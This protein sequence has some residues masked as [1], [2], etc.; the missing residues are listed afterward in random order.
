M[1]N[2]EALILLY[3]A[4]GGTDPLPADATNLDVLNAI[5]VKFGGT[6]QDS[7]AEAIAEIAAHYKGE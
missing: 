6:A 3:A 4:V 1:T 5:A 2:T 7:N